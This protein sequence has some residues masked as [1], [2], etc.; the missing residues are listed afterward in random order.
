[1]A[2]IESISNSTIG[3][4]ML[5]DTRRNNVKLETETRKAALLHEEHQ[6]HWDIWK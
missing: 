4:T 5:F 6:D 1:M 2:L 3:N